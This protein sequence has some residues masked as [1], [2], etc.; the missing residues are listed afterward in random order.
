PKRAHLR[1]RQHRAGA[2]SSDQC[3]TGGN[4]EGRKSLDLARRQTRQSLWPA[5]DHVYDFTTNRGRMRSDVLVG[6][7]SKR[8]VQFLSR[9]HRNL[10]RGNALSPESSG[11]RCHGFPSWGGLGGVMGGVMVLR[12]EKVGG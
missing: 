12:R 8:A 7:S 5:P 11:E 1:R 6:G 10:R 9:R 2:D 3:W 4:V